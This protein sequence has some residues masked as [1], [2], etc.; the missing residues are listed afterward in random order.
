VA[1]QGVPAVGSGGTSFGDLLQ[2]V[3]LVAGSALALVSLLAAFWGIWS[4][5]SDK[6]IA[7]VKEQLAAVGKEL[8][9]VERC[10]N[11]VRGVVVEHLEAVH[12]WLNLEMSSASLRARRDSLLR[13]QD[14][15]G[16]VPIDPPP[17]ADDEQFRILGAL[18]KLRDRA[19]E[20][21]ESGT[22]GRVDRGPLGWGRDGSK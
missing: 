19:I 3:L 13:G 17:L 2:V 20:A 12:V 16:N 22:E 5:W 14:A 9:A 15:D 10:L 18:Q 7:A 6:R 4:I 8:Q 21:G 1:S 11:D